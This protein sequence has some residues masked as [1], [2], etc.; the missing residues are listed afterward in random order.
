MPR[1]PLLSLVTCLCLPLLTAPG[2][3]AANGD[4]IQVVKT[5]PTD[6][7][8]AHYQ[9]NREPL[10][11]SPLVKLPIGAVKP[12]GWIRHQLDLEAE[13]MIGR[14]T[15]ISQWCTFEGN[16]WVS[17]DGQGQYGWEELPYWLKG[18]IDLGYLTG[19]QRII[20]EAEKWV[21]AVLAT[22]RPDGYFG[23]EKNRE[24]MDLWPN[25]IMLYALRTY[26]EKTGDPAVIDFMTRYFKWQTTIP[27]EKFLPGSWQKLRGGDNLDSIY[28]LYNITGEKWLL[29]L[30]RVTHECTSP[31]TQT[32][33][34]WHGVN[35]CQGFRAPG[36][37]Y[38]QSGDPR[39]LQASEN[40]YA[41]VM[42]IYGQVPGGMFGADEN[43]RPGYVGPRQAAETCSMVEFMYSFEYLLK[44]TGDGLW[45]DRCEEVTFNSLPA[46]MTPDHKALHYLT[47]PNMVQLDRGRKD[48]LLQNAGDMLSYTPYEQYRC[49][50]HN[51]SHGWPYYA[52]HLWLA[53]ADNGLAAAMYGASSVT[54]K[55]ADGVEVRIDETTDYPFSGEVRLAIHTQR[56]V[57]FPLA[58]RV[59]GWCDHVRINGRQVATNGRGWVVVRRDWKDGDTLTLELPM[60]IATQVW[61]KNRNTVSVRRGPLWYSLKIEEDWR[62]YDNGRPWKA[63]EV[64]PKSPWNYGLIVDTQ[65]PAK[66]FEVVVRGGKLADQPWTPDAVPLAL[67]GR[68][69]RI[70]QWTLE[71]N[72]L[73]GEVQTSPVSVD[74]PVEEIVLI[75]MGA[76]RLR[77]SAF[78]QIGDGP[79]ADE[80]WR[81]ANLLVTASVCGPHDTIHAL[82]DGVL[83]KASNDTSIPRFTWWEN[84]GSGQWVQYT[85][86]RPRRLSSSEVYWYDDTGTGGCR[87]PV[88]WMLLYRDDKDQW[89][90]VKNPSEYGLKKDT[91]NRVTFEPVEATAIRLFAQFHPY[92]SAGI[93]EWRVGE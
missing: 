81:P 34:S 76:A 61:E 5:L 58:L 26:H 14:L 19:N 78:P 30:A 66:S 36:Q 64:F 70:P 82:N 21:K 16:A 25:M 44:V 73:I 92:Y 89:H 18:Y 28:W 27:L 72:G 46:A 79:A 7:R 80:A 63:W 87:V 15:E 53:T 68:G 62:E 55:V 37:F 90:P 69:K 85:F 77:V 60:T 20:A 74:T 31:W 42:G 43:A 13:G 56:P 93:L 67:K 83:P 22:Q 57:R 35:I 8:N 24:R 2:S 41:D 65:E 88:K 84:R 52:Q 4:D 39:Y 3:L 6:R 17:P 49:C 12:A 54:A 86:D 59:P 50:Q 45:A 23:D 40:R 29:D 9:G 75:P 71:A 10:L 1:I 38:Q 48:P 11:P 51:V 91:F 47:A 33:A 32:V